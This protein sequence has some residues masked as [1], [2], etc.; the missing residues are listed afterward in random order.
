MADAQRKAMVFSGLRGRDGSNASDLEIP[1]TRAREVIN[2][3]FYRALFARKRGGSLNVATTGGTAF[4][5]TIAHLSRFVPGADDTAAQFFGIDSTGLV[6]RLAAGTSWADVTL[7]D[8][9]TGSPHDVVTATLNGKHFFAYKSAVDRLHVWDGSTIRR[10]GLATP[11][12]PTV[13]NGGGAGAY[14]ATPRT[15]KQA[16]TVQV[17]G[18]TVRRSELSAAVSF[19]PSGADTNATITKSAAI[20]EEET[21]WEIYGAATSGD[22]TYKLLFTTVVGTTTVADT[23]APASYSGTAPPTVGINTVPT[24]A[25][26]LMSDGSRLLLAGAHASGGKNNRVWFTP[27]LGSSDVG[28]DERIPETTDLKNRIDLD[29]NDG[30]FITGLAGPLEGY[31]FVEKYA[32]KWRLIPTGDVDAPYIPRAIQKT[33]GIGNVAHKALVMAEDEAGRPALYSWSPVGGCYRMGARGLQHCNNDNQDLTVN[34]G[35]SNVVVFGEY[36]RALKQVWYWIAT[37]SSNDPD[38]LLVFDVEKGEEVEQGDVR[39]GWSRYNG[40]IAAAR[41][42]AMFSNTL[43]ASMSRDLKPYIGRTSNTHL[44]KADTGTDDNG[45]TFQAYVDLPTKHPAGL[46]RKCA[47]QNPYVLASA[48]SQTLRVTLTADYGAVT[49]RTDDESFTPAGSETRLLK[50]FEGVEAADAMAIQV[51]VG[52][53]AAISNGWTIDAV[54]V[55]YEARELV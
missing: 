34:L 48:E 25:K 4:S 8:A 32:Q 40:G 20:S 36:Y 11:A 38:T 50:R 29:E 5:G 37:G 14:A 17:A 31:P 47:I 15:Y 54:L 19:T 2:C 45:T 44:W 42:A 51:R 30:G 12:A 52:D 28:D 46:D 9:I 26:Y 21:H 49:A 24:S 3:D 39:G 22:T 10:V 55:P 1:A 27:V 41:C 18:V 33:N 53:A 16:Y 6:K 43:G 35:A 13:A 7:K 23:T